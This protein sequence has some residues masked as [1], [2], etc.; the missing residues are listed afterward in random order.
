MSILAVGTIGIDTVETP[1]GRAENVLGGSLS[2]FAVAASFFAPVNLVSVV[3]T[4]FPEEL[5]ARLR[6][7]GRVG[8]GGSARPRPWA[9]RRCLGPAGPERGAD[10]AGHERTG[11]ECARLQGGARGGYTTQGA[12]S[13]RA[14]VHAGLEGPDAPVYA[15]ESL[16]DGF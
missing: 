12:R 15:F 7:P 13:P 2:Y 10:G 6:G 11:A 8:R 16:L 5:W 14:R 4:D 3:G 9:C 1:F